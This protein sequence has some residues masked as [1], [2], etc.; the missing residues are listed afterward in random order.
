MNLV[1]AVDRMPPNEPQK[2]S[3]EFKPREKV[4]REGADF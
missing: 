1:L 4:G 2:P 3:R